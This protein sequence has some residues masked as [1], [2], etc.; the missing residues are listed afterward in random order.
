MKSRRFNILAVV[1]ALFF[2]A[3]SAQAAVVIGGADGW[4]FSTDGQVNLFGVYQTGDSTPDNVVNPFL[5]YTDDEGFRLKSGFL[6]A[7][8]AFNIKARPSAASTWRLASASTRNRPTPTSRT[9]STP[10]ST[11]VKSSSPSTATSARLW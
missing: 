1:A 4:S 2:L 11:C 7:C 8:F 5:G 3:S 6:P 9:P 10:R